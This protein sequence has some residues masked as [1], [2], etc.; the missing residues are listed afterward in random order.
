MDKQKELKV[1]NKIDKFKDNIDGLPYVD[2]K[3]YQEDFRDYLWD[4]F[5]I[6]V[7]FDAD[8]IIID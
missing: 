6:E 2:I 3:E 4:K 5:N 1:K 7:I 8:E